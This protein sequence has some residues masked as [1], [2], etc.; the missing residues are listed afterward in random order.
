MKDEGPPNLLPPV[1]KPWR[2]G[3]RTGELP[4]SGKFL[5]EPETKDNEIEGNGK[6][7]RQPNFDLTIIVGHQPAAHLGGERE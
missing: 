7:P 1:M 3:G 5:L 6:P 2:A 4:S